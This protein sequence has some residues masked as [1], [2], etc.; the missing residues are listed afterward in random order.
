MTL[1]RCACRWWWWWWGHVPPTTTTTSAG[2]RR[3][4]FWG[5]ELGADG[6]G[7]I[8]LAARAS[9]CPPCAS[10]VNSAERRATYAAAGR[11]YFRS[12]RE[13]ESLGRERECVGGKG[14]QNVVFFLWDIRSGG[15][16]SKVSF[17]GIG[18]NVMM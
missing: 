5:K 12:E 10:H 13:V 17:S 16:L 8:A 6:L 15:I 2:R 18:G 11:R 3:R 14:R 1:H 9:C 7:C 4:D